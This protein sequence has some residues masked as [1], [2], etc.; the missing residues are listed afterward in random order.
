MY[1][2]K[3]GPN[4]EPCGMPLLI[5]FMFVCLFVMKMNSCLLIHIDGVQI[6]SF[7]TSCALFLGCHTCKV[8]SIG[9]YGQL[10]Q[11]PLKYPEKYCKVFHYFLKN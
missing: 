11:I 7:Q 5:F 10:C 8:Y 9:F 2:K 3:M 6:N 4:I 1:N